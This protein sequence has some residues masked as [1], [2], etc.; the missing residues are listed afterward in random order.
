LFIAAGCGD[1]TMKA[2]AL[3][4]V[5]EPLRTLFG[6]GTTAGLT[7]GQLLERFAGRREHDAE[8]AFAALV[9][10]HGPIV[11]RVCRSLLADPN[12]AD[13]AFQATFLVLARKAGAIRCP[14]VLGNW[15][16]GTAHRAARTL[17][18][19]A[20]SRLKHEAQRAA[21]TYTGSRTYA[22]DLEHDAA[23]REE[24]RMVH[25]EL[26]RLP[27][28]CRTPVVL[29]EL[30]GRSQEDVARLLGCSDR[31][32]P[33]RLHRAH[34][35]LRLRLSRRGL[36]P[37]AGLLA[38][39]LLPE[40]ATAAMAQSTADTTAR[41]AI[42]FAAGQATGGIV[43]A[44]ASV[45]A[46]G[47]VTAMF[48]TRLKAIALASGAVLALGM[49]VGAGI[50]V[51]AR[52]TVQD[53]E[54]R[55]ETK[56]AFRAG[57]QRPMPSPAEQYRALVQSFDVA[58]AAFGKIG[59]N[60]MTD[61]EREAAYKGHHIPHED[62]NTR[63]LA[64]AE[65]YAKDP[66]AVD[67]LLWIIANTMFY[68]DGYKQARGDAISR[69]MEI[70][71]RDHLANPRLG[72][73]CLK[74]TAYPS[75]RRDAFLRAVAVRSSDRVVRGRA[76]LALAQYLKNKGEF[77]ESLR[78]PAD[79]KA[80]KLLLGIYGTAYFRQLRAGDPASM[81]REA[82][83]LF[84]R[85]SADF[86]DVPY[87][88]SSDQPSRET[89]GDVARRDRR[90]ATLGNTQLSGLD[91]PT[92]QFRTL[93]EAFRAGVK[94]A[95]QAAAEARQRA[96]RTEPGEGDVQA[97]IAAYP[98]WHDIG[99]KMWRLAQSYPRHQAAFEAL[100]WLVEQGPRFFDSRQER[101]AVM[102]QVVDAL[103]RDHLKTIAE[104][105]ADRN[106]AMA[107]NMGE[108]LP[109]AYRERLLRALF[110]RGRD[111]T[112]RGL[113]GLALGRY[114]ENE[115]GFVERLNRPGADS[116]RR[117]EL[118]FLDPAFVDQLR[119]AD[120]QA[121]AR[122][123]EEVLERV[124]VEFG[125]VVYLNG[126]VATAE[127]L[128]AVAR[129]ELFAIRNLSVGRPA[130][131]IA[132]EDAG[133][134]AMKLSEFRGKVV[135]LDFGS[136]EHCGGCK[137]VYPRLRVTLDRLHGRPFVILGIN[138]FD[139]RDKLQEAITHGE[140]T[141]RCWWDG[142]HPDTPGP[143]TTSWNIRGYPTFILIDHRGVIRSK[144]DTHPFD[145]SFDSSIETLLKEAELQQPP[146]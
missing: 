104:H 80:E 146:R 53:L 45:L 68:W 17:K 109:A 20:A 64:L 119:K 63:F 124:I 24:A 122:Q 113:M 87:T 2:G 44:L 7:D 123:A 12:D 96:G 47:V 15:L 54:Q 74:L 70:L 52:A 73:V 39:A 42:Q 5:V 36:A 111:R 55:A 8:A 86:G 99:L 31:T 81:L 66:V 91:E 84:A 18:T 140:I 23:R 77:V 126:Q 57:S 101:D 75:P 82:D 22:G 79:E 115:A 132:G 11:R 102:S 43:P 141:W 58:W 50:C 133:G 120:R 144:D 94:A 128:A 41:A 69:A 98:K 110:E 48:W 61:A 13:D 6:A 93:D 103:I 107:L 78:K 25:E 35:L 127:N 135:L 89:L 137:L 33:R 90:R 134:K 85:V 28:V 29:C 106:V 76:T 108:S 71:T 46:E 114:L 38:A 40:P 49:G 26:A 116:G 105:L 62:F 145:P 9:S 14:E 112:T 143:I 125:D 121:I 129:R 16:Y 30:E 67:A 72:A 138:N 139:R 95:D 19:R 34:H 21:M 88:P 37:T 3:G 136:H 4:G 56:S 51:G 117:W 130:P 97:Y 131:E 65:R 60:A 10:R 142:D 27:E 59:N 83:Q 92:E 32:L 1:E 100:I 118:I